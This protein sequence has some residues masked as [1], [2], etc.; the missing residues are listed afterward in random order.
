MKT[1]VAI[2]DN[3]KLILRFVPDGVDVCEWM[4]EN[5]DTSNIQWGIINSIEKE[6]KCDISHKIA[7]ENCDELLFIPNWFDRENCEEL[8]D[9]KITKKQF[10]NFVSEWE[11]GLADAVSSLVRDS[12]DTFFNDK[13][14]D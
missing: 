3:G 1:K 11:D 6:K 9:K 14:K 8:I 2:I 12:L 5:F 7:C 10:K 13:N 4:E